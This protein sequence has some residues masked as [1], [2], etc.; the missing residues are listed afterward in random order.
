MYKS[1]EETTEV[2]KARQQEL[3]EEVATLGADLI[4]AREQIASKDFILI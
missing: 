2:G 4:Q 1:L 3:A